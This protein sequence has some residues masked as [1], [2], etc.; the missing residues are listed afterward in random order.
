[1]TINYS[2]LYEEFYKGFTINKYIFKYSGVT[3]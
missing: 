2:Q 1:M 3:V